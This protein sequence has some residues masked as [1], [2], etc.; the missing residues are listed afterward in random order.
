MELP[1][2]F[3]S[4]PIWQWRK[5]MKATSES[6]ATRSVRAWLQSRH[7]IRLDGHVHHNCDLA[8]TNTNGRTL[9][10]LSAS[11]A[12]DGTI[13]TANEVSSLQKDKAASAEF[14]RELYRRQ[15]GK[16]QLE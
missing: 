10:P 11:S 12:A 13:L 8:A 7:K 2:P 1:E 14:L 16:P 4:L 5:V 9:V 15:R 6:Y 3:H